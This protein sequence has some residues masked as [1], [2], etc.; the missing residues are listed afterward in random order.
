MDRQDRLLAFGAGALA[1]L[2]LAG[3][4][5]Y[6]FDPESVVEPVS[7]TVLVVLAVVGVVLTIIAISGDQPDPRG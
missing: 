1:L 2:A 3:V 6:W 7:L 4:A 5:L